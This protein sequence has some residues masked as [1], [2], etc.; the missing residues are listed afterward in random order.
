MTTTTGRVNGLFADA[1][2]FYAGAL[3]MLAQD[4]IRD[5]EA[6]S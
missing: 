6:S 2:K 4:R 3:E 5:A 1:R